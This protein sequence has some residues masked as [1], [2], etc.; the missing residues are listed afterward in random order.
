MALSANIPPQGC[1][2]SYVAIVAYGKILKVTGT[3]FL[4]EK[5]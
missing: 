5:L 2:H 1:F 4:A 3:R